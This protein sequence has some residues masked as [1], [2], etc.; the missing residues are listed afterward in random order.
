MQRATEA[1]LNEFLELAIPIVKRIQAEP[2]RGKSHTTLPTA[3][4][5]N[6]RKALLR[7]WIRQGK[8]F[9]IGEVKDAMVN[10]FPEKGPASRNSILS[11]T[12]LIAREEGMR[13]ILSLKDRRFR[14]KRLPAVGDGPSKGRAAS[15]ESIRA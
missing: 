7:D 13:A 10:H 12:Y 2:G 8:P 9:T 6:S 4:S 1:K 5:Y 11:W 3:S 15:T 14:F